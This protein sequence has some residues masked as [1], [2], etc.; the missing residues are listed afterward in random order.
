MR[1]RDRIDMHV[2]FPNEEAAMKV[3]YLTLRNLNIKRTA[4]HGWKE[5]L[6]HFSILWESRFPQNIL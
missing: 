5:A 6:N 3:I 4:V 1:L 2:A